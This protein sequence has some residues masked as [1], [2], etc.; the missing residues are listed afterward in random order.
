M[1]WKKALGYGVALWVVMFVIVSALIS[2]KAYQGAVMLVVVAIISGIISYVLA[3]YA[4]PAK[5]NDAL[6]YGVS[7]VV[8]GVVLD[9]L[10]TSRFNAAIFSSWSLWL[11]Y[12][13]V[14]LAPMVRVKRS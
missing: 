7:W 1:D 4:K 6:L 5:A 2:F 9:L 11:G 8:V 14:L 3:G 13:L 10:V 12:A